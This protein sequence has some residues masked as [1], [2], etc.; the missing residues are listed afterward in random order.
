MCQCGLKQL[1]RVRARQHE[2]AAGV[3]NSVGVSERE[4]N[5]QKLQGEAEYAGAPRSAG[6]FKCMKVMVMVMVMVKKR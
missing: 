3:E 2:H 1:L 5:S 6:G 4:E